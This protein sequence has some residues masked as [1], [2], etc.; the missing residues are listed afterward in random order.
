MNITKK[1]RLGLTIIALFLTIIIVS[2]ISGFFRINYQVKTIYDD[3]VVPLKELKEI[4]DN[5]AILVIDAVNK[6][7]EKIIT[8]N[9]AVNSIKKAQNRISRNWQ[10]YTNSSLT[11]K[12]KILA[13]EVESLFTVVDQEI[14]KLLTVLEANDQEKIDYY[15]GY[16]YT[17]IDPLTEKIQELI[18]LQLDI[19]Q[20]ERQKAETVFRFVFVTYLIASITTTIA[21]IVSFWVTNQLKIQ[22]TKIVQTAEIS[23]LQ[24]TTSATEIAASGKQ[25]EATITE[26]V[27]ST[28]EVTATVQEIANTSQKLVNTMD[29]VANLAIQTAH[30]AQESQN[31]LSEMKLAMSQLA[32]STNRISSRLGIMNEKANNINS[33]ITTITKVADQTNLLSLNAAIEAEKAGEYGAGF[34][35]VAREIRRLADQTAVATLEIE[36]MVKEMQTA[37]SIGVMEMDKFSREVKNNVEN[38][39]LISQQIAQVIDQVQTITPQFTLV[40]QNMEEQSQ[41]AQQISI[42]MSQLSEASQQTAEALRDTNDA[43]HGLD[44]AAH[45]LQKEI[46]LFKQ[47]I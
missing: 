22:I 28:N 29:N 30:F 39:G 12:E 34:A 3:R 15:D 47:Q 20:E 11:E 46:T 41:G 1:F 17:I 35:V 21:I 42:A 25:L 27:A 32:N 36:Q 7:D 44:D 43:L 2:G 37:V 31:N 18:E 40:N 8:N 33:V 10:S 14:P 16:L 24:V 4:S 13:K 19:A 5:Y 9:Q 38:V 45:S 26:Q 6:V 23:S